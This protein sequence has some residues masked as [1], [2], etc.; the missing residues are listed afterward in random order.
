VYAAAYA[1]RTQSVIDNKGFR[2][3]RRFVAHKKNRCK[4]I[5]NRHVITNDTIPPIEI[6]KNELKSYPY[7]PN[8]HYA[9]IKFSKNKKGK[10][11]YYPDDSYND[12]LYYKW[13]YTKNWFSD[14]FG[15]W[16]SDQYWNYLYGFSAV[17]SPMGLYHPLNDTGQYRLGI[18]M[19]YD[20]SKYFSPISY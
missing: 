2:G 8:A 13:A 9:F 4:M 15:S 17:N 7:P 16:H 5:G 1:R 19:Y 18:A 14:L 3:F 20:N 6:K 10:V 12:E 11:I